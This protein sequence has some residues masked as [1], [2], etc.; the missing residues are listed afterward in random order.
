MR[1][2]RHFDALAPMPA[3]GNDRRSQTVVFVGD[4][5]VVLLTRHLHPVASAEARSVGGLF[6]ICSARELGQQP[7]SFSP[8]ESVVPWA[9]PD[10]SGAKPY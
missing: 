3:S 2:E 7:V 1:T 9:E 5:N 8:D 10:L 6:Q 4:T